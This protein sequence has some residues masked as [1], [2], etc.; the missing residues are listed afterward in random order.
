MLYN[1]NREVIVLNNRL[2]VKKVVL[3]ALENRSRTVRVILPKDYYETNKS[4]PVLYMHDGQNL[5]DKSPLSG[6]SWDVMKTMDDMHN[7]T[8]GFII[9][10][11][12]SN[13]SKR[14]L[15]YSPYIPKKLYKYLNKKI[16]IPKEEIR[17]EADQY[18]EFIVKQL[19][20]FIDKEY[21][22]FKDRL[23]TYIAGSSC[24]GVI[25]IYLGLK[26]QEVFSVIGAFSPAYRFIGKDYSHHIDNID[27]LE[28]TK[29]YHDMGRKEN[30]LMSFIQLK[31]AKNFNKIFLNN[32][33]ESSVMMVLESKA[34]HNEYYWSIRF[35]KFIDFLYC[36]S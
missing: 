9:V 1:L 27:I 2:I 12:D 16:G 21:R 35:K 3:N 20:P 11:I 14:I 18:G 28:G 19:K 24:G 7:L 31:N 36:K 32:M 13:E 6:Y 10:G 33:P 23:N 15:E 4:Y 26:Y 8:K 17:P 34:K 25:S 30:G 22:T 29:I 5:I